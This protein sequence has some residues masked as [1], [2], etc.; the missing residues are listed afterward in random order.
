MM[1]LE[2]VGVSLK[3]PPPAVALVGERDVIEFPPLTRRIHI[4]KKT[5]AI[6]VITLFC[7]LLLFINLHAQSDG[8]VAQQ[9]K[10]LQ[11][12]SRSAQMKNDVSWAQQHLAD[13]F[14]AGDS[15][16]AWETKDDFVKNLQNK[17]NKWKSSEISDV[18]VATFG[19]STAVSHY[20]FTYDAELNGTHRARTV[21]CSDTWVNDSGTW[22]TASTHCSLVKG[23]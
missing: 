4:V 15:W 8:D 3:L 10:Q 13:G 18:H 21:I 7:C 19:S 12:D 14:M 2:P 11:Q 20:T 17:T 16:G 1:K 6:A 9:I 5:T 23:I 22:K